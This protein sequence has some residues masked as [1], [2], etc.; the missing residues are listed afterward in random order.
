[1]EKFDSFD[2]PDAQP[3][4]VPNRDFMIASMR[5]K[6]WLV[7]QP[8]LPT[9]HAKFSE[10]KEARNAAIAVGFITERDIAAIDKPDASPTPWIREKRT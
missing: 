9:S 10:Q 3:E 1:M 2:F 6:L 5:H 4:D 8:T 7:T